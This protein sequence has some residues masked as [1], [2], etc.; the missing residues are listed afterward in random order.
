MSTRH[1]ERIEWS[2]RPGVD[3]ATWP[4]TLPAVAQLIA[5]GGLEVP[6]GVTFLVG[7]NG[8]GKSTLLEAM[9]AV[10]PRGGV[11][12]PHANLTGAGPSDEDS[13]LRWHLRARTHPLASPAGFFL[14]SETLHD[15]LVEVDRNPGAARA[16]DGETLT[17]R[18]HG[19]AVLTLLRHRFGEPGVY[20]LDEPEAALSFTSALA[21]VAVLGELTAAGAQVVAATHSP[22]LTALPGATLLEVGDHGLRPTRWDELQLVADHRAYLDDPHRF[23]RHLL[24]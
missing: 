19:E 1:L 24:G 22:V 11:A 17:A 16:F 23:L 18:S 21:L 15:Y 10:Y 9:A 20:F 2:P 14:R 8:S 13:P 5:D 4:F 3:L 12:N 6:A 7:E